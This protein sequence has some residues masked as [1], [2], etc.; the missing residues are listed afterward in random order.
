LADTKHE[1]IIGAACERNLQIQIAA[2]VWTCMACKLQCSNKHERHANLIYAQAAFEIWDVEDWH[3][4]VRHGNTNW[5]HATPWE[6]QVHSGN[7]GAHAA[8]LTYR[9]LKITSPA[10]VFLL[11]LI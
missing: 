4:T 9:Q 7:Y 11:L 6:T 1:N 3:A 8:C 10:A 5:Q 2:N